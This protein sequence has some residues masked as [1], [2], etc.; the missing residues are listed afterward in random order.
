MDKMN[1][2]QYKYF[3]NMMVKKEAIQDLVSDALTGE[4]LLRRNGKKE[5][6]EGFFLLTKSRKQIAEFLYRQEEDQKRC[7]QEL[8][9]KDI[10]QLQRTM[11]WY[12]DTLMILPYFQGL[13]M[14]KKRFLTGEAQSSLK[15]GE[16]ARRYKLDK[17]TGKYYVP[18]TSVPELLLIKE[19]LHRGYCQSMFD[20]RAKEGLER[21]VSEDVHYIINVQ[22]SS[23]EEVAYIAGKEDGL[24]IQSLD[25]KNG[26]KKIFVEKL[27]SEQNDMTAV[28]LC[29]QDYLQE[30]ELAEK[31]RHSYSEL[32]PDK[33]GHEKKQDRCER[34]IDKNQIKV[35]DI[36]DGNG[37]SG[38]YL[39]LSGGSL[40]RS[41]GY[42]VTPHIRKGHYRTYKN[43]KTVYVRASIVHKE[44][45]E[46]IQSAHRM[47]LMGDNAI[48]EQETDTENFFT[49][50]M[51]M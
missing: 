29:L 31:Q 11:D 51:P 24:Y 34:F 23:Q 14:E 20:D 3:N 32:L 42:E 48:P 1:L 50:G 17:E 7:R 9:V 49:Q 47:N 19:S 16:L 12:L 33:G 41:I 6:S 26:T 28:L 27:L 22:G 36:K 38:Y 8:A 43:G 13:A 15:E 25:H 10:R 39:G 18:Y 21:L 35:F 45:Y 2:P 5:R 44:K 37:L 30:I 46:G 40:Q 4:M